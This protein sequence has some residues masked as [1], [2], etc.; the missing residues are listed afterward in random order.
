MFDSMKPQSRQHIYFSPHL[1]DAIYSCGGRIFRQRSHGEAVT[2]LNFLAGH[3]TEGRL[4]PF[5]Q[6]Y[7]NMWGNASDPIALRLGEDS[8]ALGLW[9]VQAIYWGTSDAIYRKVN[10]EAVYPDLSAL[11]GPPHPEDAKA[12]MC[13]WK[14]AW[15]DLGFVPEQVHLYAPLAAGNHVDHVLVREFAK[16]LKQQGWQVWFYEDFPHAYDTTTLQKALTEFGEVQWHCFTE[17]ID[18]KEKVKAMC[19]YESQISMMFAD[20]EDMEKRVKDFTAERAAAIH[21]GERLRKL[22][23]GSGGRRE[24]IWRRFFGY[25]AHAERYWSYS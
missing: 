24:R 16:W 7:H 23:A 25:R 4:T 18:V 12:L 2:V 6:Q 20:R 10:Q 19:M 3:P 11:F 13:F 9:E 17:L 5:A 1:D 15:H 22:L 8:R 14:N 21:W